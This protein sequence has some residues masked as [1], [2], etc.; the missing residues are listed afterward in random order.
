MIFDLDENQGEWFYFFSSHIDAN[1]QITYDDPVK[2]A[3]V[4]IRSITP[5]IEARM[6]SKKK[7]TEHVL[8]P[9]TRQ[10]ERLSYFPDLSPEEAI[11]ERDDVWDYAI[12]AL[13][14]FKDGKTGQVIDCTR[15]NKIK[16]IKIP[17]FDRFIARCL[18][19]IDGS[20]MK[21]EDNIIKNS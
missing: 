21:A 3:R 15:E 19:I 17:I 7:V 11:K 6:L 2:D 20:G 14:N 5:F 8:N 10:M 18:Q 9:K 12:T 4:Q 13:E 16:L 1:G